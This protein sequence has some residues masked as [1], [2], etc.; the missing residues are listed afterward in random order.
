MCELTNQNGLGIQ[1]LIGVFP[2]HLPAWLYSVAW[3][4]GTTELPACWFVLVTEQS[5]SPNSVTNTFNLL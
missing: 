3:Q 1:E 5:G 2:F 4:S